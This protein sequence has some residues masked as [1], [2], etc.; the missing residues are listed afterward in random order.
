MKQ[1]RERGFYG[2][3][4]P[5]ARQRFSTVAYSVNFLFYSILFLYFTG[6]CSNTIFSHAK[7]DASGTLNISVLLLFPLRKHMLF[8]AEIVGKNILC[9]FAVYYLRYAVRQFFT[10]SRISLADGKRAGQK[11]QRK[12]AAV[13]QKVKSPVLFYPALLKSAKQ[14]V[15]NHSFCFSHQTD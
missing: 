12:I 9:P 10:L 3:R 15:N 14:I 1:Q 13:V 7:F 5:I 2:V 11:V 8:F 4:A 6:N